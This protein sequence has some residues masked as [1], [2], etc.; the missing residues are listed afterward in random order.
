VA[1]SSIDIERTPFEIR[2]QI[3]GGRTGVE[4]RR[5]QRVMA[6]QGGEFYQLSGVLLE[7]RES[8]GVA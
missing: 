1:R 2:R 8:K 4:G 5:I 7:V 6:E 3:L